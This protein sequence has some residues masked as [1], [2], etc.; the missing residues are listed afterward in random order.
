MKII[1]KIY[2]WTAFMCIIGF[3]MY[4][5]APWT[6]FKW[7]NILGLIG[8]YILYLIVNHVLIC[9]PV[10]VRV[11]VIFELLLLLTVTIIYMCNILYLHTN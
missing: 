11:I 6:L 8:C 2:L 4:I 5:F 1:A 7:I 10:S 9:K 3:A